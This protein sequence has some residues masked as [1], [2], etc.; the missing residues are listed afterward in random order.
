ARR[1]GIS[2]D[3]ARGREPAGAERANAGA[4][5]RLLVG[6][7]LGAGVVVAAAAA[8]AFVLSGVDVGSDGIALARVQLG[9]FAGTIRHVTAYDA[10]GADVPVTEQ[11]GMVTPLRHLAPG[12]LLT[13]EVG[14]RRPGSTGWALGHDVVK[15]LTIRTPSAPVRTRWTTLRAGASLRV[16]F[17]A[18]VTRIAYGQAGSLRHVVLHHPQRVVDLGRQP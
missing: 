11:H 8:V 2:R 4:A 10:H 7:L 16:A 6:G 1:R 3:V 17:A 12:T 15:R 13:V 14:V 5:K 18:P 9:T